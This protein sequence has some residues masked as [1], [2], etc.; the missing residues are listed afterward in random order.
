MNILHINTADKSGGA[1]K[2]AF[3]LHQGL[4]KEGHDSRM[5]VGIK[6]DDDP[7]VA[8]FPQLETPL[9]KAQY[10][11]VG[12]IERHLGLQYLLFPWEKELFRHPFIG[13][14]S[15]INLH[16]IHGG[17]FSPKVLPK[18]SSVKPVVWTL[19][20]PWS[21]T[22]HC[23][24]PQLFGCE[25]WKTGCGSCPALHDYPEISI[26]TTAFLWKKKRGYYENSRLTIVSPSKWLA[27]MAQTSPLLGR[28]PVHHI[29]YGVDT[30]VFQPVIRKNLR[31]AHNLPADKK[32]VLFSAQEI[33]A[34]RKGFSYLL[35]ALRKISPEFKN[36]LLLT[37][38]QGTIAPNEQD[39]SFEWRQ[40]NFVADEKEMSELYGLADVYVLPTL[41]DNLPNAVLECLSSGTPVVA[42][43]SGGIP[44]VVIPHQTGFV[45]APKDVEGLAKSIK[46]VLADDTK[47]EKMGKQARETMEKDYSLKK[48]AE[49]YEKIYESLLRS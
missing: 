20:D 6:T 31:A 39:G 30:E 27:E 13:K 37:V 22:G 9:E 32:I 19:H 33:A 38:G 43:N 25:R 23:G 45:V 48:Q 8:A 1:A 29:P 10:R 24:Y 14:A 36:I 5:L 28:F 46:D 17:Y 41:A 42:F 47:R 12:L 49:R 15:V 7:N 21:M 26:D 18:L 16:N 40:I 11:A 2:S 44:D 35:E 4:L 3:R 34:P